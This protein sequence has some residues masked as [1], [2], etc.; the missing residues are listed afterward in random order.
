MRP[1]IDTHTSLLFLIDQHRHHILLAHKKRGFGTHKYNGVGGK[2]EEGESI[3]ETAI[4]ECQEEIEVDVSACDLKKVGVLKFYYESNPKWNNVCHVFITHQWTG[5]PSETEEMNPHWFPIDEIPYESM[6]VDDK[7]WLPR[8]LN[9][10]QVH[11]EFLFD[12]EMNLSEY[13]ELD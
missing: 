10:H 9:G 6:W 8:V 12:N 4:R 1:M 13:N 11:Y 5:V 7:L 3:E 2:A